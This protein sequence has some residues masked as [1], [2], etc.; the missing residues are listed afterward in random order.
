MAPSLVV[1][2]ADGSVD[3]HWGQYP[4]P[5][6]YDSDPHAALLASALPLD[7]LQPKSRQTSP[8]PAQPPQA[9]ARRQPP[10]ASTHA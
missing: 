4:V 9:P 7:G 3:Y 8:T 2:N 1:P 10:V 5:V 6:A